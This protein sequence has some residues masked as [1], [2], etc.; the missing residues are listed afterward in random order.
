MEGGARKPIIKMWL[1]RIT[2]KCFKNKCFG[3]GDRKEP[4]WTL[5]QRGHGKERD[6]CAILLYHVDV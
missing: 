1:L 3:N 4:L 5:G 6:A 2:L